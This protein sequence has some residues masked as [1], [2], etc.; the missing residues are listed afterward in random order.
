MMRLAV[1]CL[2]LALAVPLAGCCT[3]PEA[4]AAKPAVTVQPEKVAAP[5]PPKPAVAKPKP[6]TPA[7][8]PAP[9]AAVAKPAVAPKPTPV[10]PA[11]PVKPKQPAKAPAKTPAKPVAAP[12][13]PVAV[14]KAGTA[15]M[16]TP[17]PVAPKPAPPKPLGDVKAK[18]WTVPNMASPDAWQAV[19]HNPATVTAEAGALKVVCEGGEKDKTTI[20]LDIKAD[21]T[22]RTTLMVDVTNTDTKAVGL[23]LAVLT[24]KG[25]KYFESPLTAL[26]PGMNK[27]V[28]F[29]LTASNYKTPP[30]Y[31]EYVARIAGLDS[32]LRL[33]FIIYNKQEATFTFS[34]MRLLAQ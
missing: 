6:P 30:D 25:A 24:D 19:W 13:K 4:T 10:A 33:C 28:T 8:K 14:A 2:A 29:D 16:Q 18:S 11:K 5:T 1:V 22:S 12:P 7:P 32:V 23:A 9:A 21:L 27:E 34:N 20:A 3:R 31:K 17:A 26:N 15:A